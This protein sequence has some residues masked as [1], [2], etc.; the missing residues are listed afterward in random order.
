MVGSYLGIYRGLPRRI[1]VQDILQVLLQFPAM[2]GMR[3]LSSRRKK[4]LQQ[5]RLENPRKLIPLLGKH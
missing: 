4:L 5:I 3:Q 1:L 2:E